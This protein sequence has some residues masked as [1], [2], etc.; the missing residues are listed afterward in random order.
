MNDKEFKLITGL[1]TKQLWGHENR[2]LGTTP[3]PLVGS[4]TLGSAVDNMSPPRR[5][6]L[7]ISLSRRVS[8]RLY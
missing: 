3:V 6:N 4:G 2:S 5:L 1:G 7:I 8:P